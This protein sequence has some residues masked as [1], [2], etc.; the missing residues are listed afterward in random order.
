MRTT[1]SKL[2]GGTGGALIRA[3]LGVPLLY[4]LLFANIAIVLAGAVA[5]T[6]FTAGLV[7]AD[8]MLST[9][10]IIGVFTL[11]GV[12]VSALANFLVLQLALSPLRQ[13]ERAAGRVRSGDPD[14]RAAPS[15]L[16]DAD[17][18]QL[19]ETFNNTL[20]SLA[21]YRQRLRDVA[22]A[23]LRGA[24]G[25]RK[26]MALE[27]HDDTAPTLVALLARLGA[28]RATRDS[29]ATDAYLE[30]VRDGLAGAIEGVR[31]IA[32]A[33]RPPALEEMGVVGAVREH[34]RSVGEAAGLRV[35]VD[36]LLRK[37]NSPSIASSRKPC[38]TSC[39]MPP[40]EPCV[41]VSKARTIR[42]SPRSATTAKG[43]P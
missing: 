17:L 36:C 23:A 41:C 4:K 35:D 13:L 38:R 42:S 14:V 32:R 20:T 12:G 8:P 28:A 27:L 26:R 24:E 9:L 43:S 18:T 30:E 15:A 37:R 29:A 6:A 19:T 31:R 11:V 7:R 16:A 22:A 40:R 34:A 2:Q 1:G 39:A 25:E 21:V 10:R 33:L 5:G 3:L